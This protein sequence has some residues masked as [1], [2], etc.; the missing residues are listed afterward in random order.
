MSGL[1]PQLIVFGVL[2]GA[3]VLF[4]WG[5]WRYDVVALLALLAVTVAGVVPAPQAFAGFGHPA[6]VIVASVLV[7]TR[8]L[9]NSGVVGLIARG[10]SRVGARRTL[11][12]GAVTGLTTVISGFVSSV[13]AAAILMPVAIRL[14][15]THGTPPSALL[16]PLAFGSLLGATIT[17]IGSAPNIII[18]TF[19]AQ[20]VGAPFGMFDY[21][22]VGA[23]AAAAGLLFIALIGWRLIPVRKGQASRRELFHIEDYITEIRVPE[24]SK[25]VGKPLRDL[26]GATDA[27]IVVVGLVR[28]QRRTPAPSSFETLRADDIAIVQASSETLQALVDATGV[29]LVGSQELGEEALGSDEVGLAEAVVMTASPM[30][31]KTARGLNLR[32][33]YG[34]NLLA[35]AR[36]GERL[37]DRL[38][39]IRFRAGDVLLLQGGTETLPEALTALGCLPLAERG[40][41][42]GQ[43]RRVLSAASIGGAALVASALGLLPVQIA[44]AAAAVVMVLAGLVSL[45]EAYESVDW[46]IIVLLGAM[47]PVGQALAETGGARLLAA[48]LLE[49]SRGLPPVAT[50]ALVLVATMFL[51]DLVNN[52]AAALVM[53]PIALSVA[54]GLGASADPF[55]MS[56]AVGASC[57]FL[58]PIGH[59]SNTL[60][61]GPGGYRFGDYWRMGL[62]LEVVVTV[63][64]LPL[65]VW[66]WPLGASAR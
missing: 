51:S 28:G 15:R 11:Q 38:D 9:F 49:V 63:V 39:R 14:A 46:P 47:I 56:V 10:M 52:A 17:L 21:T 43:P 61:M 40:L 41:R 29:E 44:F 16:M 25:L 53:A 35:V 34:I 19:R 50:L 22:P 7:V 57:A 8:G 31:G 65:L 37:G 1:A 30:E 45:R 20:T 48:G 27:D 6:V 54:Q 62:P 55:L 59:Q 66:F 32:W 12:V 58:T 33:R 36:Q 4:V 26:E 18:A 5:R 13:A 24:D 64:A 60:V 2:A 23:G 3:L 42:V